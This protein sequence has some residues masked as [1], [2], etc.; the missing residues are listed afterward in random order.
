VRIQSVYQTPRR[1]SE[2][3]TPERIGFFLCCESPAIQRRHEGGQ[4]GACNGA[5]GLEFD[6]L[7][8]HGQIVG[9]TQHPG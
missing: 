9:K 6:F 7:P 1:L 5:S 2:Q 8:Q 3:A 4:F